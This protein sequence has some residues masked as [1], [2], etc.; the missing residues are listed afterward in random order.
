MSAENFEFRYAWLLS[1]VGQL[2]NYNF[3]GFKIQLTQYFP[4]N[5]KENLSKI[6]LG[7]FG[8]QK[9][10]LL[11]VQ[12]D[13]PYVHSYNDNVMIWKDFQTSKYPIDQSSRPI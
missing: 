2:V 13:S 9:E 5:S 7:D 11:F 6:Y 4:L 3:V 10:G 8:Y 1:N 12:K